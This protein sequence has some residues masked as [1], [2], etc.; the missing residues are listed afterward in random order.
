MLESQILVSYLNAAGLDQQLHSALELPLT[1]LMY[2]E[3]IIVEEAELLNDAINVALEA[4]EG[5]SDDAF[6]AQDE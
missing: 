6:S 4:L 1:S 3:Q 2:H 5:L